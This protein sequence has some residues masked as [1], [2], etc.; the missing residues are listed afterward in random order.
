MYLKDKLIKKNN[1]TI[2]DSFVCIAITG[3]SMKSFRYQEFY[4]SVA[5]L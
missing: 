1:R 2:S 3:T 4:F 5:A